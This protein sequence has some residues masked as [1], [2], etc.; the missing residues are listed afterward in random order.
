MQERLQ[1]RG[2]HLPI[3][4]GSGEAGMLE[5]FMSVLQ[6]MLP[7]LERVKSS[8]KE[9][10]SAIP[11]ASTQLNKV[12][13]ATETATVEILN[14]LEGL[15]QNVAAAEQ[16]IV[17]WKHLLEQ[18]KKLSQQ[19]R[20]ELSSFGEL[21][22]SHHLSMLLK[23]WDEVADLAHE[24]MSICTMEKHLA[25]LREDSLSIAMALQVQDITTQQINATIHLIES[26][27]LQLKHVLAHIEGGGNAATL[28]LPSSTEILPTLEAKSFDT[29][30][31]Y[32]K[33]TDR[34]E[35]AD[36]I[37]RQWNGM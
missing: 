1:Q 29:Q 12:T 36:V 26:V 4:A 11:K 28:P 13:E 33:A 18:K 25:K 9:T 24:E 20:N 21:V 30:A 35:A 14:V 32:S 31:V 8:I 27:Q 6:S 5:L 37:V 15:S 23:W 19:I 16:E 2:E 34:Q 7:M 10:S 3:K 22:K 17:R